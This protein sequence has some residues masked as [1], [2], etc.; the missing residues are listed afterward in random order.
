[1]TSREKCA[2]SSA[3]S[4]GYVGAI[5]LQVFVI[6]QL[7]LVKTWSGRNPP[8]DHLFFLIYGMRK[9]PKNAFERHRRVLALIEVINVKA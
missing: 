4:I 1:M 5:I 3:I 2:K 8:L 9:I 6:F 7:S